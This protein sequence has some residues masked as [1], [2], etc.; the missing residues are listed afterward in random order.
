MHLFVFSRSVF[1]FQSEW[2]PNYITFFPE[3]SSVLPH[4]L[5]MLKA[6]CDPVPPVTSA[7]FWISLPPFPYE[8]VI[9]ALSQFL[10]QFYTEIL[11]I[12]FPV[13]LRPT[14]VSQAN[15]SSQFIHDFLRE[16]LPDFPLLC[17]LIALFTFFIYLYGCYFIFVILWCLS[18][19][20]TTRLKTLLEKTMSLSCLPLYPHWGDE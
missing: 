20:S 14:L 8:P 15:S 6:L 4:F 18:V 16:S 11:F 1:H 10:S 5:R 2:K 13:C 17:V 7:F 19:T 12:L 3:N 9:L